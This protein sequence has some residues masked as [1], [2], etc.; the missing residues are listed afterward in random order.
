[1]SDYCPFCELD[2]SRIIYSDELVMVIR[3][4]FPVAV[5]HS[6][7]IP[8]RHF[9]SWFDANDEERAAILSAVDIIAGEIQN[10]M[11][12][13]GFNIGINDGESAGQTIFH[14]HVHLIPRYEGD[15]PDPRGGVRR[16]FPDKAVYWDD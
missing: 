12:P 7:V 1:M 9:K 3:D 10:E 2:P 6:L 13:D 5:G 16:M 11:Q 15:V 14:L 4:A 8:K